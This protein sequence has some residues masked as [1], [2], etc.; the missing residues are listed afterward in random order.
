M[1]NTRL[2]FLKKAYESVNADLKFAETKN[3]FLTS[4]NLAIIA[5]SITFL[6]DDNDITCI[7]AFLFMLFCVAIILATLIASYS[8]LPLNKADRFFNQDPSQV[9]AKNLMFYKHNF[10]MY[11]WNSTGY[12]KCKND[13]V[14]MFPD[15][16]GDSIPLD[17]YEEQ[18]VCQIVDLSHVANTKFSLFS[19]A[20]TVEIVGL[21][22]L[23]VFLALSCFSWC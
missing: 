9:K 16:N 23:M 11:E 8:Y 6:S 19:I 14:T 10:H 18:L 7:A 21:L 1:Y 2:D 13:V 22:L 15:E 4:F 12:S 17:S 5:A 20:L 3:T